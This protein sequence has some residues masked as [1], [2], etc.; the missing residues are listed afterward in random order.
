MPPPHGKISCL[1]LNEILFVNMYVKRKLIR[2]LG[3]MWKKKIGFSPKIVGIAKPK[4]LLV[5]CGNESVVA[6]VA[7][8][9]V[10]KK[11]K[12]VVQFASILHLLQQGHPMIE[13]EP[14]MPL[15]EFLALPKKQEK[16]IKVT[17]STR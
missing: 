10:R 12:K 8:G 13:Y 1:F 15:F 11:A 5:R 16:N 3:L 4:K 9:M 7:N 17:T 2:I 14:F 6:Q